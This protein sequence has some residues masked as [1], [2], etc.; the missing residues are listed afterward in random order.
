M[1][2]DL[3]L[4]GALEEVSRKLK[5]TANVDCNHL[6]RVYGTRQDTSA[7]APPCACQCCSCEY[8]SICAEDGCT[9][10]QPYACE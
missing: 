9:E 1:D 7:G 3:D 6:T 4:D 10:Q 8:W 5:P 2:K